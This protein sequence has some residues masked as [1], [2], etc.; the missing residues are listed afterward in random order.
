MLASF[1]AIEAN[2]LLELL[3]IRN[4]I[5]MASNFANAR[6]EKLMRNV[7]AHQVSAEAIETNLSLNE[8]I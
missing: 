3:S 5:N 1:A 6:V 7:G 4:R 2:A 8:Q